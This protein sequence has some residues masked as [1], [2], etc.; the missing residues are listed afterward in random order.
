[1]PRPFKRFLS[2][3][4][5][6]AILLS[7]CTAHAQNAPKTSSVPAA[8]NTQSDGSKPA[9]WVVKDADTTIY[10]FGTV[11]II[12]PDTPWFNE[13][14]KDA[15]DKSDTVVT[16]IIEPTN[17]A[18]AQTMMMKYAASADGKKLSERLNAEQLAKYKAYLAQQNIPVEAFDALDPWAASVTLALMRYMKTGATAEGGAEKVIAANLTT[19]NKKHIGL[20]KAE[21]QMAWLDAMPMEEQIAGLMSLIED[22]DKSDALITGMMTSWNAGDPD[23]LAALINREFVKTPATAKALLYDRNARWADWIE[24]RMEEPGTVFVAVGAGHLAGKDSVQD[25]LATKKI[26]SSRINY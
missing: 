19:A 5:P 15:F 12:K 3:A 17:P 2:A 18:E 4:A 20:E 26:E 1:M 6:L 25:Y 13:A 7:G 14:V 22:Q 10:L 8:K 9:I 21:D 23:E 24:K 11:H 16:E